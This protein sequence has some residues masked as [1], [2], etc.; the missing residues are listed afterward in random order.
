MDSKILDKAKSWLGLEY[1]EETRSEVQA[2]IDNNPKEL[3]DAFYKDLDFGTGGLRGVMGSGTNRMNVYTVSMATQGLANYINSAVSGEKSVA[4]AHDSRNNSDVFAR[5]AA[6]VLAANGIKVYLYPE[7]RP[8]PQL[9]YTVRHFGCSAGLVVTASHNPKEYN[10]YKVYWDDGGQIVPPHDKAIIDEVR[11]ISNPKDV[12]FGAKDEMIE[13]I[14]TELD[15]LY[16]ETLLKESIYSESIAGQAE[17][18][19][20]YTN[21]HGTGITQVPA[22]LTAMGFR[23]IHS[24]K[25]QEKPD[26]N[27]PTVHSPNPEEKAALDLSLQLGKKVDAEILMGTDPDADRVGIAVKDLNGDLVLLNGNETACMLTHYI[28]SGLKAKG[29]SPKNGFVCS[30]IVTTELM[31]RIAKKFDVPC[32]VT[33]TGFKWIAAQIRAKENTEK[34]ICG[35]EESYG[36]MIGDAVRDKDAVVTGAILCEVAAWAKE[37]GSSFYEELIAMYAEYGFFREALVSLVKK[38]KDGAEQIAAMMERFRTDTPSEIAGSKVIEMRDYKTGEIKNF[39]SG[40]TTSTG[41]PSSNVIQFYLEDGCKVTARPSGTEPKIKFYF[42]LNTEI[43]G[44]SDFEAA[45][46]KMDDRIEELK[47]AFVEA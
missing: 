42:S 20:V 10:G 44:K 35:G 33:L 31:D 5:K 34:F 17:M 43:E 9:S 16:R 41:L 3:E 15:D 47:V 8:T 45:K 11:K 6:E 40:E 39:V 26:G 28:L 21:L 19:I 36:F 4:I 25:E 27:F 30:T 46:K 32:Y 18:P 12:K 22:L 23:N 13:I 37:K 24:V 1:D 14:G 7:L 29:R 2:L 38:G